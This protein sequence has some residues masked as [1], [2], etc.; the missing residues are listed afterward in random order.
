MKKI[1]KQ[2]LKNKLLNT[3][4]ANTVKEMII[5]SM[6]DVYLSAGSLPGTG[7]EQ[8]SGFVAD[9]I[10]K[11]TQMALIQNNV[12]AKAVD[13][14]KPF[15]GNKKIK[16]SVSIKLMSK[17]KQVGETKKIEVKKVESKT[18]K[19]IKEVLVKAKNKKYGRK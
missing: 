19:R 18:Q 4:Q 6:R 16:S 2:E 1:T 11:N 7:F 9:K 17:G 10:I 13:E 5:A 8:A 12:Y 15:K 3:E 14:S